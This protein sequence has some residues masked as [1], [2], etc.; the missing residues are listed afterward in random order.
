MT[1]SLF[2]RSGRMFQLVRLV[3]LGSSSLARER[4]V[5]GRPLAP[6]AL[7]VAITT[8]STLAAATPAWADT[9]KGRVVD[10]ADRPVAAA[11][12]IILRGSTV[13]AVVSTGDDGQFGPVT[14]APDTYD[15]SVA[16]SGLRIAPRRV[17]VDASSAL[18]LDLKMSIAAVGES[19]VVSAAHVE[20]PASRLADSVTVID[21]QTIDDL[22]ID[23][24]ADALQQTPGFSVVGSGGRGAVTSLF[25]RGG[26]SDYTLVLV[27]GIQQNGFGGA[28]DAGHLAVADVDRI[29]VVRGPQSAL[30]GSGAI[31]GIVQVLTANGGQLRGSGQ[32]EVGGYGT[33]ATRGSV[34]GS[35]GA[36]MFGGSL[37]WLDTDGDTQTIGSGR[38]ISNDDYRRTSASASVAWSDDPRRR[39]RLDIRAGSNERG[40]PGAYGSDPLSLYGGI[41]TVSRGENEDKG[42]NLSGRFAQGRLLF[43]S[44][45]LNWSDSFGRF[46]SPSFFDPAATD[47]SRTENRRLTGRYQVD[48]AARRMPVSAGIEWLTERGDNTFITDETFEPV[49]IE[50]S[51]TGFFVEARPALADRLVAAVGVRLERIERRALEGDGFSRPA[52][53]SQAVWSA[54]PKVSVAWFARTVDATDSN[55]GWTK[56][57]FGAGSGIKA[58]TAFEIAFTD[59]PDL[60]PERSRSFDLGIEQAFAD[61]RLVADATW[62]RNSYDDLIIT[63][64][65]SLSGA[66]RYR[67]DN[68]A[69]ARAQGLELGASWRPLASLSVRGAWSWLDTEVLDVDNRPGQAPAP[70]SV[71]DRLVRRP[72]SSGSVDVR[73]AADRASLFLALSGRGSMLD[74]EPNFASSLYENDGFVTTTIGGAARLHRHI[75]VYAR[76]NNL[77]DRDYEEV[78][79]FPALGRSASIGVRVTTGR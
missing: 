45:S 67:T 42:L 20:A 15:V 37:D 25:P 21:R 41:D 50:R 51:N 11:N 35:R 31:G 24:V 59:N 66:S 69:N 71:G 19:I 18:T 75:D 33:T 55:V 5:T 54:N 68:I 3:R 79:G 72:R 76:V 52:F 58:P 28:F 53:D 39:V 77:F 74:L 78:F 9:I 57:R 7:A 34:A 4:P 60:Q 23:T 22:Q 56:L 44:A 62:F 43:H 70:Y 12:V 14:L 2:G 61:S 48:V 47:T 29:E 40:F 27:D 36:W 73:W 26:E 32:F 16:A 64:G 30:Y 49:P 65:Q 46:V 13:V 10:P 17:T 38:T 63:V 1:R 8:L 6:A